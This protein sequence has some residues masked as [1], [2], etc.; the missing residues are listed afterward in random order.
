MPGSSPCYSSRCQGELG[1]AAEILEQSLALF[2]EVGD[3]PGVAASLE[4]LAQGAGAAQQ[5][6]PAARQFGTAEALRETV[7][8]PLPPSELADHHRGVAAVRARLGEPAFAA[9]WAAG[10]ALPLEEAIAEAITAADALKGASRGPAPGPGSAGDPA[11]P[12][13]SAASVI[14]GRLAP[15]P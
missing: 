3:S 5:P 12:P 9:A 4:V 6:A 13:R 11:E 2:R 14:S 1:W 8:V 10:R 7:G 15:P